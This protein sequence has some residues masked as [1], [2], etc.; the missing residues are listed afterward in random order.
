MFGYVVVNKPELKIKDFDTYQSFYC[1]LCKALHEDFGRRG[2]LTLN[3]D[4][5][6][7][8]ILLS[9]L[10]EPKDQLVSELCV[11]HPMHRH[12]KREND[13]IRYAADMTI[14]LT[15][16]K[17]EDDWKDEHSLQAK[18]MMR[19]LKKHM[20]RM[21]QSYPQK[22]QNIRAALQKTAELEEA[23]S[24]DLDRLSSLS[25]IMLAE[26]VTLR[27][28]EWHDVLYKLGD[29]LGRF[30][31][32]MDAYDDLQDDQK[33]GQFN[34]F[35][36]ESEQEGFDE[37]VKSILELMISSSADAFETL[38]ILKY[39]DILRN[40][41]YSGIWTKYE[42]VRKKRTGEKDG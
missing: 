38:P 40:I 41:L 5:T 36:E 1:G 27:Q 14:V 37:R 25:G 19:L 31:Y 28:D 26:I 33:Q 18:T 32:I 22:I 8:A 7:L 16:L 3:F 12:V 24:R 9:A 15:Y 34:P 20:K 29:Y 4:L 30:I 13:Y 2:Q 11:V 10:Y 35:L 23:Q 17:C 42:M 6:F 39:A 21:E